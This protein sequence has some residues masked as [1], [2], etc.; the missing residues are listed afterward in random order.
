MTLHE[1]APD[2]IDAVIASGLPDWM[3]RAEIDSLRALQRAMHLQQK[4]A[5]QVRE[6]LAPLPSID[7]FAEPLLKQALIDRFNLHTDVRT[8]RVKVVQKVFYPVLIPTAPR[9]YYLHTSSRWLLAAALHNYTDE[10]TI[11]GGME[12]AYLLDSQKVRLKVSFTHFALLCRSLDIGARYQAVLKAHLQPDDP[13]K[14]EA[15]ERRLEEDL[16]ARLEVALRI[17]EMRTELDE[18]SYL[19]LLPVCSPKPIV[20]IDRA[21]LTARQLY[22]LGK[23]IEGV[24]AWEVRD[25]RD[26]PLQGV[27]SWIP[28]DPVQPLHIHQDWDAL[29]DMLANRLRDKTYASFFMRFVRERDRASFTVTLK[30][31]IKD[32][33]TSAEIE[34][35][36]RHF[37]IDTPVLAHLRTLRIDKILDDAR[38]LAVPTGDEDS[39]SRRERLA[40]YVDAG[41]TLLGIAGLFVPVLGQAMCVIAAAQ[42]ANEIYEGYEDWKL[43]DRQNALKHL[44]GVAE[45]VA[46]GAIIATGGVAVGRVLERVPFVDDLDPVVS[47]HGQLRLVASTPGHYRTELY[48][49]QEWSGAG[50]MMR[51][52]G[53]ELSEVSDEQALVLTQVTG[54][55]EARLRYLHVES[56][57]AP[58]R[59]LDAWER[60]HLHGVFPA[61]RGDAFE[62]VFT[63]KQ[64]VP[65]TEVVLLQRDFPG[66]S[67]RGAR[68]IIAQASE[69]SLDYMVQ[70]QRVPLVLAEQARWLV[71]DSRIDR[72]LAGLIQ[73]SATNADSERLALK[74]IDA[75]APWPQS[76]R[77]EIRQGSRE[78]ALSA[79]LGSDQAQTVRCL[80]R[81]DQ[82]YLALGD[83]G[84][85]LA[86]AA[87]TDSLVKALLHTLEPS[88]KL[89][90][91]SAALD[92]AGLLETL[93]AQASGARATVATLIGMARVGEGV[94]PP[95]RF[96]DGRLGYP[97]SGR[98]SSSRQAARRGIHQIYP[99][100]GEDELEAY[101][102]ELLARR[103][104]P[105][106]H[107]VQLQ[108]QLT[109]LR[110]GLNSWCDA[111]SG[112][113][114][115]WRRNRVANALRRCWRRKAPTLSEGGFLLAIRGEHVG[116]LP[117]LPAGITF[118]HVTR[119]TLRD[120]NL[121]A[122]DA[123]F[124]SRFPH[125]VELDLQQNRFTALPAGIEQLSGLRRL[126]LS[127]NQ[128]TIDATDNQRLA[129]LTRLE[130]LDLGHNP[131][132][133]AL[134]VHALRHL[135]DLSLNAADLVHFPE[136]GQQLPVFGFA[137]L[138]N[139]R[140]QRIRQDLNSLRLR[141]RRASV[142]DNPLD[143]TSQGLVNLAAR[144]PVNLR[145]IDHQL[146]DDAARERWLADS[147][148][149]LRSDREAQWLRLRDDPDS[150]GLFQFLADFSRTSDFREHSV[151]YRERVWRILGA[152]DQNSELRAILLAQASGPRTCEDQLLYILSELEVTL[153]VENAAAGSSLAQRE[154]ALLRVGRTLYRLDE[155]N[156]I[157]A[158]KVE[159]LNRQ[160]GLVDPVEVYLAYRS[161]LAGG[162]GLPA[163]PGTIHYM[164][165]SRVTLGDV[166]AA[167]LK[168]LRGE[169]PPRLSES[170]A[171]R[172]FWDRYIHERYPQR[173]DAL[174]E[175]FDER[176]TQAEQLSEQE[177]LLQSA[178][179]RAEYEK[180]LRAMRLELAQAAYARYLHIEPTVEGQ[181][182]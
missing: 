123:D 68:E 93:L 134:D 89:L 125:L 44:F 152:C 4:S 147:N 9:T 72:A 131:L 180:Q 130:Q 81:T 75:R 50:M 52:L 11:P 62:S 170:L 179:L 15:V 40:G 159:E 22:L 129:A 30:K 114:D 96:A 178:A 97:L 161:R 95:V 39:E 139:N 2:S 153:Y 148:G 23:R 28:D 117:A 77:V 85:P 42:L 157:A 104:D 84:A 73:T 122:L 132:G 3:Q 45:N 6:L 13:A 166:S 76:V 142:H 61:L 64:P 169:S 14:R 56:A 49:P 1:I 163:Q 176:L 137:D 109:R 87:A 100:L 32:T 91:G 177:Y 78:G 160:G 141:L 165:F 37:A 175:S 10:E 48:R 71:R 16:R 17:A 5:Q 167:R 156:R 18:R 57:P 38:V 65:G 111:S 7:T 63:S 36:G 79:Q 58:A 146:L 115:G 8:S 158:L 133:Q 127:H 31:L 94:R 99:T 35:D 54:I 108:R 34:L 171:E 110:Q 67:S 83:Q 46:V 47:E 70:K 59:L 149:Q 144:Q 143:E 25:T 27:L 181:A 26:G 80:T 53:G 101:I 98:A 82:G 33:G 69:Q 168:I 112:L 135:R 105:W 74:L 162:L 118:N 120:M 145:P 66:L 106:T 126:R 12:D 121:A 138:R 86:Q 155:V 29:Y 88:Q 174:V 41:L 51:R 21:E 164:A 19:Q 128:I 172:P 154:D 20:P 55:D 102:V 136:R 124:L 107:Y 113:R 151:Y 173:I 90:L 24:A 60:Y 92:E 182:S 150:A 103:M 119:L 116:G 43:G 140:I